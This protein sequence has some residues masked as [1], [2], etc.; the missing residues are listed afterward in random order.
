MVKEEYSETETA[1]AEALYKWI[2]CDA[3]SRKCLELARELDRT[4]EALKGMASAMDMLAPS[5][6][7]KLKDIRAE[8]WEMAK[9]LERE[10]SRRSWEWA[11]YV[12][13]IVADDPKKEEES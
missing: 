1:R 10:S 9:E 11:R 3:D 12:K 6:C 13:V 2:D 7:P 8:L 5:L 4:R